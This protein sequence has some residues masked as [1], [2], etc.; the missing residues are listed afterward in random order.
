M[1]K[2]NSITSNLARRKIIIINCY[3]PPNDNTEVRIQEAENI[4]IQCPEHTIIIRDFNAKNPLWGGSPT[5]DKG[6]KVI[7]CINRNNLVLLND[8]QS[9][10]TFHTKNGKSW[11]DLT[12]TWP[13]LRGS[14]ISPA[15]AEG[16]GAAR[17]GMGNAVAAVGADV[18]PPVSS[19]Q[20]SPTQ[21]RTER[22][23]R[24]WHRS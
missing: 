15:S 24:E 5:D 11:I 22:Q 8:S 1:I 18:G 14:F 12:P 20:Q 2:I 16:I 21:W 17:G 23:G 13:P 7:E 3:I 10:P 19:P 4:L 6:N 9:S